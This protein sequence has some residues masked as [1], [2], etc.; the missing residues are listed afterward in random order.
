MKRRVA[1]TASAVAASAVAATAACLVSGIVAG[2][3][4]RADDASF[5]SVDTISSVSGE[6]IYSRICQGC[7]MPH[8]EGAVGAGR[9]PRLAGDAALVSWQ[10]VAVTVLNGRNGMPAF[11]TPLNVQ[12]DSPTVHLSDA[13]IADLVNYLRSHFGNKYKE[14]VAASQVALLPHPSAVTTEP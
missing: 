11:G 5:A 2:G 8:G 1:R 9:Y 4:A 12:W 3:L 7:H 10:Y 14:R 6:D 13:Q